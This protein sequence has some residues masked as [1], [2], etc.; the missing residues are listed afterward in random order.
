MKSQLGGRLV[1]PRRFRLFL[2]TALSAVNA[3]HARGAKSTLWS[4]E[5]P[6]CSS[7]ASDTDLRFHDGDLSCCSWLNT[8]D[9]HVPANGVHAPNSLGR[10]LSD[11]RHDQ[12]FA[13]Q[14]FHY[15]AAAVSITS[16]H[17]IRL[18]WGGDYFFGA[19]AST[20]LLL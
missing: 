6:S 4:L 13:R 2:T 14:S 12:T 1:G 9:F 5:K 11:G 15:S 20:L 16:D 19:A 10:R 7:K 18:L 8:N 17:M 3:P